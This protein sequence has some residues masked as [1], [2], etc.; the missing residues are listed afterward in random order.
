VTEKCL[1]E[2]KKQRKH[3]MNCELGADY[4]CKYTVAIQDISEKDWIG[5]VC[6]SN[7]A[8]KQIFHSSN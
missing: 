1:P 6:I 3:M 5:A 7:K 4:S 2:F 8:R